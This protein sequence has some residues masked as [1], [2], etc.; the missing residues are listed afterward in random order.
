MLVT[1]SDQRGKAF[2]EMGFAV[3]ALNS[4]EDALRINPE[5]S[6]AWN[7]KG[8]ILSRNLD[9]KGAIEAFN[10][11][12]EYDPKFW[13]AYK[14]LGWAYI[15]SEKN[16]QAALDVLQRG[17]DTVN[18][19]PDS[20]Y[21]KEGCGTLK[22]TIGKAYYQLG[23]R[24]ENLDLYEGAKTSYNEAIN[25]LEDS[26][27]KYLE[28]LV[29]IFIVHSALGEQEEAEEMQ[30]RISDLLGILMKKYDE[31][32]DEKIRLSKKFSSQ[33]D[34]LT[35][36][37]CIQSGDL[38]KA[39]ETAEKGKNACLTWMMSVWNNGKVKTPNWQEM[40]NLANKNTAIIYWHISPVSISTF[41][42]KHGYEQPILVPLPTEISSIS[43]ISSIQ[44]L[45]K[46]KKWVSNWDELYKN[47]TDQ[48][49]RSSKWRYELPSLI[50]QLGEILNTSAIS[51][52]LDGINNLILVPHLDLHRFPLHALFLDLTATYLPSLQAGINLSNRKF[53]LDG[54][55]LSV[56]PDSEAC[57][58]IESLAVARILNNPIPTRIVGIDVTKATVINESNSKH[59]LFHF[60]GHGTSDFRNPKESA[61]ILSQ[62]NRLTCEDILSIKG[63]SEY[64]LV[65][66]SACET[67]ITGNQDITTEYVGLVSAFLYQGVSYILS[68]LWKIESFAS[69]L[70]IVY[71]YLKLKQ[72]KSP[73]DALR[74]SSE[75]L[76]E[77][78]W[79]NIE[80]FCKIARRN[81]SRKQATRELDKIARRDLSPEEIKLY[82]Y[83]D[84]EIKTIAQ[85]GKKEKR[86]K[87]FENP[88]YTTA[89]TITGKSS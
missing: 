4:Y 47:H 50:N 73:A 26:S 33:L 35:V 1:P 13:R 75:W 43:S 32:K 6:K 11:S 60:A 49:D 45:A 67:A 8:N 66:L 5:Y 28:V 82:Y 88:Y 77:L 74:E 59:T 39:V 58:E 79:H 55:L 57:A 42:V 18:L 36:N 37:L 80:S 17:L 84:S 3:D 65:T 19:D 48:L 71:F 14:N 70:I 64:H 16:Y 69:S 12:I 53:S 89:F 40:K 51:K 86:G 62:G 76:G 7:G 41:I 21:Y 24:E 68:T 63:L 31:N 72:G 54:G 46:F 78:T 2:S 9:Y 10:R 23:S 44:H 87:P 56:Q 81:I 30:R 34:R 52:H 61:L 20:L 83:L 25:L 15:N 22:H 27:E 38:I 29:D 85:K